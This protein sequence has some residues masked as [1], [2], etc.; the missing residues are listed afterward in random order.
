MLAERTGAVIRYVPVTDEGALDLDAYRALLNPRTRIVAVVHMSNVLGTVNPVAE[1]AAAAREIGAALLVDGCQAVVHGR[2]DVQA[3]GCDFYAFSSHK[4][5][6][7]T[8]IGV[9]WGKSS[10]WR[11]CRPGRAGAR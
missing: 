6:G 5:Y 7:P 9:L 2:V 8:G 3:L 1:M 10:G 11:P 4:L